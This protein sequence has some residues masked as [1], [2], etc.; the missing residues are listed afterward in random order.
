MRHDVN[1]SIYIWFFL[2]VILA[3]HICRG[4]CCLHCLLTYGSDNVTILIYSGR[5]ID[6]CH[7][8]NKSIK[9]SCV[10][11]NNYWEYEIPLWLS[12]SINFLVYIML[13]YCIHDGYF[14]QLLDY[15]F[16]QTL[17]DRGIGRALTTM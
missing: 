4:G 17:R 14:L 1:T 8:V 15:D 9:C 10:F 12:P 11:V 7:Y 16:S 6:G 3:Q 2:L 13:I 5:L